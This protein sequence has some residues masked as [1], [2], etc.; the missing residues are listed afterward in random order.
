M[1][2]ESV[3]RCAASVIHQ[4]TMCRGT[5]VWKLQKKSGICTVGRWWQG[6]GYCC[7]TCWGTVNLA[8]ASRSCI[9]SAHKVMRVN[10]HGGVFYREEMDTGGGGC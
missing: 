1:Q 6:W 3:T 2:D 8:I 9:S 10:F 7:S 5:K 4:T